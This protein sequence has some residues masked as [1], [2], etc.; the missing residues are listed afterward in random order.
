MTETLK[1]FLNIP[2]DISES[3]LFR[4]MILL[5]FGSHFLIFFV[6]GIKTLIFPSENFSI[7]SAIRVDMVAL[8]DKVASL[9][10]EPAPEKAIAPLEKAKEPP[11]AVEKP[12]PVVLNPQKSKK[13]AME[14][15]KKMMRQEERRKALED[16]QKDVRQQEEAERRE[17]L[18]RA[19]Q[20]AKGN[21]I[22]KGTDMTGLQRSEFNEYVGHVHNHVKRH[23]NL[24]EWLQN[25]T[26]RATIVVYLDFR[27][28]IVKR[29]L[30]KSSGDSTFDSYAM[31]A[32]DESSPFPEPPAKF[33]DLLRNE[34]LVLG[35]PQ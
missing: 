17:N 5:S 8:P 34:G 13:E 3:A 24:P 22:S 25:D 27:G 30:E 19:K 32:V 33:K 15:V 4:K 7:E 16:I 26:L 18:N 2:E 14:K 1:N 10:P 29:V 20:M 31:K 23:W 9:P 35:F 21:V 11:K 28:V 6:L 12:K